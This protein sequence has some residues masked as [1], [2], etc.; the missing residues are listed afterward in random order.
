MQNYIIKEE[1]S[2]KD[3]ADMVFL[4]INLLTSKEY[5]YQP[6]SGWEH[7]SSDKADFFVTATILGLG[8]VYEKVVLGLVLVHDKAD[9]LKVYQDILGTVHTDHASL[10]EWN[11]FAQSFPL[12]THSQGESMQEQEYHLGIHTPVS[13]MLLPTN[14]HSIILSS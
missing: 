1:P 12:S 8:E 14:K 7:P 10:A 13:S 2:H 4:F 6:P 3:L 11:W 5:N 9:I